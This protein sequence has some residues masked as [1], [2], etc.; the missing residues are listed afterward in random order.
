MQVYVAYDCTGES[1]TPTHHYHY[2]GYLILLE[3]KCN[4]HNYNYKENYTVLLTLIGRLNTIIIYTSVTTSRA[5][6]LLY[7]NTLLLE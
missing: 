2:R 5:Q 1:L 6:V 7:I 4:S 3:I